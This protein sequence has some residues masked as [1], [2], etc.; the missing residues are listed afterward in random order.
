MRKSLAVAAVLPVI[1]LASAATPAQAAGIVDKQKLESAIEKGFKKQGY[2]IN[3]KCPKQVS[4]V[5]GKV[6]HCKFYDGGSMGRVKVTLLS[7]VG[8]GRLRWDLV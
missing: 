5:K 7:G 8:V 4:W 6:F 1:A 2:D 3:A